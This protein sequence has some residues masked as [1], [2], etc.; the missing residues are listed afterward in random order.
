MNKQPKIQITN[1]WIGDLAVIYSIKNLDDALLPEVLLFYS[2]DDDPNFTY[3]EKK[4]FNQIEATK[5]YKMVLFD[6]W[7]DIPNDMAM[8]FFF[9]Q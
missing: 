1:K 7:D 8:V 9:K 5:P 2:K 4:P 3:R 6:S